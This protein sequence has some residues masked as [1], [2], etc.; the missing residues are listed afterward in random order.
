MAA[1]TP[2]SPAPKRLCR[3]CFRDE[4]NFTKPLHNTG[5]GTGSH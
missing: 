1:L 5:H 4:K 2:S 3:P